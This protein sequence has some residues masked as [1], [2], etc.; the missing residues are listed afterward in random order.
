M[1]WF[2]MF[3]GFACIFT[4][5]LQKNSGKYEVLPKYVVSLCC[6]VAFLGSIE[7]LLFTNSRVCQFIPP[8]L[9]LSFPSRAHEEPR[10]HLYCF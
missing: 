3:A 6:F 7:Y 2:L 5:F 8:S 10:D 9:S 4:M 1:M